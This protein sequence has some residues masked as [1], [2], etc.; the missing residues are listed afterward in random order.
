METID[1]K[2]L[3]A[4]ESADIVVPGTILLAYRGSI[5]HG[6][7]VPS[8]D[9]NSIDD[10]D[11]IG[12]FVPDKRFYFGLEKLEHHEIFKGPWDCVSYE[13]R[14]LANMLLNAN[15]NVLNLLWTDPKFFLIKEPEGEE[16]LA[17]RDL[18]VTRKAYHSFTGYAYGQMK[19]MTALAFQGYMGDKRKKLVEKFGYDTKN[20]SHLI[21][22]LKMGIEFLATG[23]LNVMRE[24][25]TYLV[26]IKNGVYPLEY[27]Q[28]EAKRLFSLSEEG[29]VRSKLRPVVDQSAAESLLVSMLEDG[30]F[31]AEAR[32]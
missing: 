8:T 1:L 11:L 4:E 31:P 32:R 2:G 25:N 18:F 21:R 12:A 17:A 26:E 27:I 5:S 28:A 9:P 7:Y 19:K 15:P 14:K 23:E 10:K 3:S 30:L 13:M 6:M 22:L 20:A 24:D 29:L 16:L